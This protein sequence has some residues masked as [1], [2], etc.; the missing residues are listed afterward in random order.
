MPFHFDLSITG[1]GVSSNRI[2]PPVSRLRQS[3]HIRQLPLMMILPST[4]SIAPN[5][6]I[7]T[8]AFA[9]AGSRFAMFTT[10]RAILNYLGC[11]R[12]L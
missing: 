8:I 5:G 12:N 2:A 1:R 11:C 9:R 4:Y 7:S 3:R 6:Q 10:I